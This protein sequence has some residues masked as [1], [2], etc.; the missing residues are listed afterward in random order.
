MVFAAYIAT[1]LAVSGL[2]AWGMLRG[3][4]DGYH[5]AGLTIAIALAAIFVPLQPISGDYSARW[6]SDNQPPKLAALEGLFQTEAGAPMS[7]GG[8]PDLARILNFRNAD[9]LSETLR[10]SSA[11]TRSLCISSPED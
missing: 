3:R 2:Y 5:R 4:R 7:I 9:D 11:A 8:W 1:G 6:V 10:F